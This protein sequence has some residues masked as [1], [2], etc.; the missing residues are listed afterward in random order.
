MSKYVKLFMWHYHMCNI[1]INIYFIPLLSYPD[2]LNRHVE[3]KVAP[4]QESSVLQ[5]CKL[6]WRG[7]PYC[8]FTDYVVTVGVSSFCD[9]FTRQLHRADTVSDSRSHLC[10]GTQIR[11][12]LTTQWCNKHRNKQ[13]RPTAH[14]LLSCHWLLS[15]L[16]FSWRE[17]DEVGSPSISCLI[18]VS[19]TP[20]GLDAIC[21]QAC[22]CKGQWLQWLNGNDR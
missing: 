22:Y 13:G 19:G 8:T 5:H 12:R 17:D 9:R 11:T 20:P 10:T 21:K 2:S 3:I 15:F 16:L 14:K 6:E 4:L 1:N 18:V 7:S